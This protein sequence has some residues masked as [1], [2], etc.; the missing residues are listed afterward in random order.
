MVTVVLLLVVEVV[1]ALPLDAL[2]LIGASCKLN[3]FSM[4]LAASNDDDDDDDDD[5][6]L[7]LSLVLL[8]FDC[9]IV[10]ALRP[11]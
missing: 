8:I 2:T 1:L 11:K 4:F 9:S 7:T 3:C 5:S 6:L 10:V